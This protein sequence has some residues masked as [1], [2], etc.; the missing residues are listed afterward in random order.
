MNNNTVWEAFTQRLTLEKEQ[1]ILTVFVGNGSTSSLGSSL[2]LTTKAEMVLHRLK[3]ACQSGSECWSDSNFEMYLFSLLLRRWRTDPT[4]CHRLHPL[5]HRKSQTQCFMF[6]NT[7]LRLCKYMCR[8]SMCVY[9]CGMFP[10]LEN[11]PNVI[12]ELLWRESEVWEHSNMLC[13]S[14]SKGLCQR[15]QKL[16]STLSCW[17]L[18]AGGACQWQQTARIKE[19]SAAEYDEKH[20]N[21]KEGNYWPRSEPNLS[22]SRLQLNASELA[23]HFWPKRMFHNPSQTANPK[24]SAIY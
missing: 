3:Q 12:V 24:C 21:I 23:K 1:K 15:L 20:P 16:H 6:K 11:V 18:A 17:F 2:S 5:M 9:S 4:T 13:H 8:V 14:N 10:K 7:L 22:G 19:E